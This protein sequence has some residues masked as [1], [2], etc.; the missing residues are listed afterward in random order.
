MEKLIELMDE[1][2]D[3][4]D[5]KTIMRKKCLD[6]EGYCDWSHLNEQLERNGLWEEYQKIKEEQKKLL[7]SAD[8]FCGNFGDDETPGIFKWLKKLIKEKSWT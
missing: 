2:L 5:Q 8:Y 1:Y 6:K 4:E 7:G 3:L